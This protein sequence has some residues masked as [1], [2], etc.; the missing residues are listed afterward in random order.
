MSEWKPRNDYHVE[1]QFYKSPKLKDVDIPDDATNVPN[2]AHQKYNHYYS[3]EEVL[4]IWAKPLDS[5]DYLPT[6]SD[7]EHLSKIQDSDLDALQKERKF[8]SLVLLGKHAPCNAHIYNMALDACATPGMIFFVVE[9][10]AIFF[11]LQKKKA[12]C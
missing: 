4:D 1:P 5:K 12:F 8:R 7:K 10:G 2:A 3:D 11:R 6:D 9:F